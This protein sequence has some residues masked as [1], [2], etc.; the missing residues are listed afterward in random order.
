[1]KWAAE[2]G[3]DAQRQRF[4]KAKE[5]AFEM[6]FFAGFVAFGFG[7]WHMLIVHKLQQI[8]QEFGIEIE[9]FTMNVLLLIGAF[10]GLI[11]GAGF[12]WSFSL[13]AFA[14]K[15]PRM[16]RLAWTEIVTYTLIAY[17]ALVIVY[18]ASVYWRMPDSIGGGSPQP[19]LVWI[20]SSG[21]QLDLNRQLPQAKCTLQGQQWMCTSAYLLDASGETLILVDGRTPNAHSLVIPLSKV[22]AL[23]K[24][25]AHESGG[26]SH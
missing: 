3:P 23:T 18:S 17:I 7:A 14:S 21:S 16:K 5:D 1:M 19:V 11:A 26:I 2:H 22:Q 25:V 6:P 15:N 13:P 8:L 20:D 24:E 10:F 12:F 9:F 4:V